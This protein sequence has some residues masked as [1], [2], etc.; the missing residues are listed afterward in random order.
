[1]KRPG[2]LSR[3]LVR[4]AHAIGG[5]RAAGWTQQALGSG[6]SGYDANNPTRRILGHRPA[7][8][9]AADLSLSE[10]PALRSYAR[11]LERNNPTARAACDGTAA[12]VVG[13]GIALEP[14]Q[15]EWSEDQTDAI[16][17]AWHDWCDTAT[18][19]G[20]SIYE[21]Q[22]QGW[23]EVFVAGELVWR[24]VMDPQRKGRDEIPLAVVPLESEWLDGFTGA[25]M[26]T[27]P[28]G[29]VQVGPIRLDKFGR[30]ISY[31]LRNP[32]SISNYKPETVRAQ[33]IAH[34]FEKRRSMQ[35]RGE[36]WLAPVIE[37]LTQERD[38]V[39]TEL[40]AAKT[41]ASIGLA[42]TSEMH[43]EMDTEEDGDSDDPAQALRIGGVARLY[44]GDKLESFMTTRP[45]QQIMPFRAGLRGDSAAALRV[46]QRFLDRDISKAGSYSAMRGDNQDEERLI[47]PVR[48]W[49]GH[50][51]IGRCYREVL[52]FL[53]AKTGVPMPKRIKYKLLPD[54]QPYVDPAKDIE[55]ANAAINS[56]LSTREIEVAKRGGD[57]RAIAKQREAE[58]IKTALGAIDKIAQIQKACDA[59]GVPG[60][61]WSHIV[62]LS[63]AGSA[64]GAYLGASIQAP[65]AQVVAGEEVKPAQPAEAEEEGAE[66]ATENEADNLANGN[67]EAES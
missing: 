38:L 5:Q 33:D 53:C 16:R 21:L 19:D 60:L 1:M 6:R 40:Q 67:S 13:S 30:P 7:D 20:R 14:D 44:P 54:G 47:G 39:A 29:S 56:G 63:G 58:E 2:I 8:R 42:V 65:A 23:R 15:P 51:T 10:L 4:V 37:T 28:D 18:I 22:G 41:G 12:L 26:Q 32:E 46:P 62:T 9:T 61:T 17:K 66:D 34:V 50:G 55:A 45:S 57:W 43:G 64:P 24:F 11:Q 35:T 25:I 49:F 52:P 3:T 27:L 48:D 59:S 36:S 31:D